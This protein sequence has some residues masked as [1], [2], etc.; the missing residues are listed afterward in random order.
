MLGPDGRRMPESYYQ[1][2][3]T[4]N[5]ITDSGPLSFYGYPQGLANDTDG[6][7]ARLLKADLAG[8]KQ[9]RCRIQTLIV[10]AARPYINS[11][12]THAWQEAVRLAKG[13]AGSRFDSNGWL[14]FPSDT[15]FAL[16][17]ISWMQVV[18][19][20]T[21]VAR[22]VIAAEYARLSLNANCPMHPAFSEIKGINEID[23]WPALLQDAATH[24]ANIHGPTLVGPAK[25]TPGFN[26]MRWDERLNTAP[27]LVVWSPASAAESV[28]SEIQSHQRSRFVSLKAHE[29]VED[30]MGKRLVRSRSASTQE[31]FNAILPAQFQAFLAYEG[32]YYSAT[33]RTRSENPTVRYAHAKENVKTKEWNT[34]LNH[35]LGVIPANTLPLSAVK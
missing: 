21:D 1:Q 7:A 18:Q 26:I 25:G 20:G 11:L 9:K 5:A 29:K 23:D 12:Q 10:A 33:Y 4:Y 32:L 27:N 34:L 13:D 30:E 31:F 2:R 19:V 15:A 14:K 17:A 22:L 16:G 8:I 35:L 24:C 3:T 28:L 6:E